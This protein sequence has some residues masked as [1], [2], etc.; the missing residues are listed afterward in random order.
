MMRLCV[1]SAVLAVLSV[2]TC[3]Y[4]A[5]GAEAQP[6]TYTLSEAQA[7]LVLQVL[8]ERRAA[9]AQIYSQANDVIAEI[10]RQA[11]KQKATPEKK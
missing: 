8:A 11:A 9:A 2:S 5:Y 4:V 7:Q 3:H 10:E 6:P 1:I